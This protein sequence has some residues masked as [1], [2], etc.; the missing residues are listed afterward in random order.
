MAIKPKLLMWSDSVLPS[1]GTGF[2]TVSRYVAQALYPHFDIDQLAI[3][4]NGEFYNREEF[5]IQISPAKLLDRNDPYGNQMFINNIL[6]GKYDYVWIMND[7]FIV[8]KVAQELP[9]LLEKMRDS[10]KKIPTII[11]YYPVDCRIL[12]SATGML[13]LAD[14]IVAYCQF[15]KDETLKVLPHVEDKL[16]VINHGVDTSTFRK[17]NPVER[18]LARAQYLKIE[19]P[20][21]FVWTNVN[22]NSARKDI[23]RTILAFS[24][25]RKQVPNSKLYLHTAVKDTTLDLSV[26]VQDLGLSMKKDVLFPAN[27]AA[28]K[29]FPVEILNNMYNCADAYITT[30]LGGGFELT[31]VECAAVSIPVVA[32]DYTCFTEQFSERGYLYPCK[33]QT[34]IDNSGFRRVGRLEDIVNTMLQCYEDS[35]SGAVKEKTEAASKYI[36]TITWDKIGKQWIELFKKIQQNKINKKILQKSQQVTGIK[37]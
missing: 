33:E 2:G 15:G 32:P 30:A 5:P 16:S 25:F 4:Y 18:K 9:A 27:Y 24:E 1:T 3:N 35:K 14:Y 28:H 7:T 37:L 23:A 17:L 21:T 19:D 22:R 10:R 6:T 12:P 36:N 34:Y 8:E 31:G 20:D 26:P 11:Y 29:P 13:Q